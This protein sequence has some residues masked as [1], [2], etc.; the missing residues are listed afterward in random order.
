MEKNLY[1]AP[2]SLLEDRDDIKRS[3]WWKIYFFF[4][5]A[6]ILLSVVS[7]AFD[8]NSG[9]VEFFSFA[10]WAPA[11]VGF[12][13]YVYEKPI[14]KPGFWLICFIANIAYSV[15]YYF[16][17]KMDLRIGMSDV[18]FYVVGVIGW[19]LFIPA[20]YAVYAYSRSSDPV[21][22]AVRLEG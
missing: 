5:S 14:Y 1:Q 13:G 18:A 17:T 4:V 19:I 7:T 3:A 9:W 12:Y 10:I 2:E 16:I 22:K 21:W 6:M 11:M 8:P 20:Y 15:L